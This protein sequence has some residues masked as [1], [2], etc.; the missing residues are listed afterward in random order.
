MGTNVLDIAWLG[1]LIEGEGCL[2]VSG[3]GRM[4][5]KKGTASITFASTDKDV[6]EKV[7]G[8]LD[9]PVRPQK[10]GKLSKKDIWRVEVTGIR[11]AQWLMTLYTFFGS[12]RREKAREVLSVWMSTRIKMGRPRK[13]DAISC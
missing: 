13:S 6:V 8:M 5:T 1:G 10:R 9:G 12:R 4:S 3:R 7:A 2:S 11:A